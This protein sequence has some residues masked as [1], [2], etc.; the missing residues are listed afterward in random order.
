MMA[1]LVWRASTYEQQRVE[2][3]GMEGGWTAGQMVA[4]EDELVLVVDLQVEG[5]RVGAGCAGGKCGGADSRPIEGGCITGGCAGVWRCT[6]GRPTCG[7]YAGA[8]C[9]GGGGMKTGG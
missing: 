1:R 8:G 7:E 3:A 6:F 5:R 9:A 4:V 2:A